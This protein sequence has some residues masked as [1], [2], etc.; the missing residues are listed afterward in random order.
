MLRTD[1]RPSNRSSPP[2]YGEKISPST[3]NRQI[4]S[5]KKHRWPV[6]AL[7]AGYRYLSEG[8]RILGK[9]YSTYDDRNN[10]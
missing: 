9:A 7:A 5:T 4:E 10:Q 2:I 1:P 8:V 6:D 3:D